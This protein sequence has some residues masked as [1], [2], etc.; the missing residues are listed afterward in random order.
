MDDETDEKEW[1][2]EIPT[3]DKIF[4][5]ILSVFFEMLEEVEV[6]KEEIFVSYSRCR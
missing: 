2:I 6:E 1:R 3:K 4:S 5:F